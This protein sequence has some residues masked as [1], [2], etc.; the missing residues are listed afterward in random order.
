[1]CDKILAFNSDY[2]F[3]FRLA[4]VAFS[5]TCSTFLHL[6]EEFF[7]SPAVRLQDAQTHALAVGAG[8][9]PLTL[10]SRSM[11][12][13]A[14]NISVLGSLRNPSN[15]SGFSD[16]GSMERAKVSA[17]GTI[18]FSH[19]LRIAAE[20]QQETRTSSVGKQWTQIGF[21]K[22]MVMWGRVSFPFPVS[23]SPPHHPAALFRSSA[24]FVIV[25]RRRIATRIHSASFQATIFQMEKKTRRKIE[26]VAAAR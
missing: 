15:G 19:S 16:P 8:F 26:D 3:Y 11:W 21:W 1:M 10:A 4:F 18:F 6:I 25:D 13:H 20:R 17:S 5:S 24:W 22:G 7:L 2:L 14:S 12:L 23:L 9:L